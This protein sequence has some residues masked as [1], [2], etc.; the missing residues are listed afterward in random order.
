MSLN[1]SVALKRLGTA[2]LGPGARKKID[3]AIIQTMRRQGGSLGLSE[4][5]LEVVVL[6]WNPSEVRRGDSSGNELSG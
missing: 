2:D 3:G 4:D 1:R 5:L 6:R